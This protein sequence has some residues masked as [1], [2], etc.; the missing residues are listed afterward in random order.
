MYA[1]RA[2]GPAG[3]I[4]GE[5][6]PAPR[7]R[8]GEA[9]VAVH[10]AALTA[11]ELA[12]P[13]TWPAIPGH[14][15]SGT[16]TALGEGVTGVAADQ[17]V[18]GLVGFDRDGGAAD[19][20]TLPAADLAPK[21]ASTS[22]AGAASLALAALTAWQALVT[23]AQLTAGQHVLVNG[24]GGGVGNYAVQLAHAL[25][26]RVTAT[27]GAADA[28]FVAG[29][30]ADQVIDYAGPPLGQ[31][32]TGVDVVVDTAGGEALSRCWEVLRPGGVLVGVASAPDEDEA[33]RHHA[34]GIYFIVEPDGP[35]LAELTRLTDS[36]RLRPSIGRVFPLA[37]AAAAFE[38][39]EHQHIRGKVVLGVRPEPPGSEGS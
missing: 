20:V 19:Y 5:Q 34:R 36:G 33:R 9:L 10:A 8:P 29:L 3:P 1:V 32:V 2:H 17:P 27:A 28:G 25:G 7:P 35:Q 22:H 4:V 18:Y 38:A 39:L 16:V 26:A 14:E 13:E 30:G 6:I 24:A 21:P 31:A 15:V 11:G 37:E 12:W 23:H